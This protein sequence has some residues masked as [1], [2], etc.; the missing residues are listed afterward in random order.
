MAQPTFVADSTVVATSTTATCTY[1]AGFAANDL[2]IML[3]STDA[4]AVSTPSGWTQS[5]TTSTGGGTSVAVFKKTANGNETGSVTATI[6]GG[7]KGVATMAAYRPPAGGFSADIKAVTGGIDTDSSSTAISIT[8]GSITTVTDDLLVVFGL[9]SANGGTFTGNATSPAMSM[10]A[11]TLGTQTARATGRAA[12]NTVFYVHRDVPVV[13]GGT[14]NP[15]Y[16]ATG[17]GANASGAAV[18]FAIRTVAAQ[19][20]PTSSATV[21]ASARIDE[22]YTVTDTSSATTAGAVL[23][24]RTWRIISG[25][26]TLSSTTAS[27]VTVT[28]PPLPG[29]QVIG[30]V[31]TDS[32]GLN[33][34]EHSYSVTINPGPT[35]NAGPDQT[36]VE[37]LDTVQLAGSGTSGATVY[38]WRQISGQVVTLS[39]ATAQNPTFLAPASVDGLD[40]VFG[41]TVGVSGGPLSAEDT[42]AIHIRPHIE[43]YHKTGAWKPM[44]SSAIT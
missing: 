40:L 11:G 6:T 22:T 25:G 15:G 42:V 44:T 10:S 20:A 18:F 2:L 14:G 29:T 30:I 24:G 37:A 7:T 31:A 38:N 17:A 39:S 35:A 13:T 33:G 28:A 23:T 3:V 43:W 19:T 41:L 34:T 16:T 36:A 21:P 26:G 5:G 8:G 1:P 12:T 32:N 27:S 9:I 4:T